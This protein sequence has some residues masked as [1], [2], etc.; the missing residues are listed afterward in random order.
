MGNI[1]EAGANNIKLATYIKNTSTK[2]GLAPTIHCTFD[3]GS[4]SIAEEDYNAYRFAFVE[5]NRITDFSHI[6]SLNSKNQSERMAA[7]FGLSE[8]SNFVQGFSKNC[9]E[10]YL[11][12]ISSTEQTFK[13]QQAVRDAKN[14]ELTGLREDLNKLQE[15]AKEIIKSIPSK[16]KNIT[17]LRQAI[18]YYDNAQT[19]VLTIK[20]QNKEKLTVKLMAKLRS[21][22]IPGCLMK[23]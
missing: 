23:L 10:K 1:E 14:V 11:P 4:E 3:D 17:T 18:D 20:I 6:S 13:E 9:D 19:G 8:F 21:R 2:K 16:E 5:K 15:S 12:I 7:L 22:S